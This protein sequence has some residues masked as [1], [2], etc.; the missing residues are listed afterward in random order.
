VSVLVL[1]GVWEASTEGPLERRIRSNGVSDP[2]GLEVVL[3]MMKSR[4][5][6]PLKRLGE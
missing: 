6:H 2:G 4:G 1:Q 5:E 3:M